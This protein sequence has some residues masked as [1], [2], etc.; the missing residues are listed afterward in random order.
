VLARGTVSGTATGRLYGAPATKRSY[1]ASYFD[2]VRVQNARIVE[3]IQ[4]ADILG[5]MRQLYG[6]GLGLIGLDAMFLRL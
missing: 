6:K 5:Q 1:Q 4:Q 3:R 2:Y